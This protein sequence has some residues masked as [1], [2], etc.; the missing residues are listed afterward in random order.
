[1]AAR[2]PMVVGNW[3]MNGLRTHIAEFSAMCEWSKVQ[4]DNGAELVICPPATLLIQCASIASVGEVMLGTQNC[5]AHKSG[6]FTG[7]LS[8]EMLVD[9]GARAVILGHSERREGHGE[10]DSDVRAKCHVAQ[11][12]GL[13]AI[14]CVGE[15]AGERRLGLTLEVIGRQLR[16]S[17]PEDASAANTVIAYEPVWAIGA[18]V[19]PDAAQINAVHAFIRS[20]LETIIGAQQAHA[21]RI[22]YGGS[23]R[24][25][26]AAEIFR[27][28]DVDGGLIGG[29][30][31]K[32]SDF[33]AI[34]ATYLH[35]AVN[36]V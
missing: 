4:G 22:L 14:I 35:P 7:E 29:A 27:I 32:A 16:G 5:S 8:A 33:T 30:S 1:M 34:A 25:S 24:P 36:N 17:T 31:L 10:R 15:T 19:T 26:N 23:V 21:T 13:C 3:K 12:A 20:Q 6:A 18:G 28:T 9:A 2:R 11:S